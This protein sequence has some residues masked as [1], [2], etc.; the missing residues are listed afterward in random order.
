MTFVCRSYDSRSHRAQFREHAGD[1]F[2]SQYLLVSSRDLN[3]PRSSGSLTASF[4]ISQRDSTHTIMVVS[5]YS[6]GEQCPRPV[7]AWGKAN[8]SLLARPPFSF[9]GQVVMMVITWRRWGLEI[10][11][12]CHLVN[13]FPLFNTRYSRKHAF[14]KA[15]LN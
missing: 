9:F 4:C 15:S 8:C 11:R 7:R 5:G 3:L 12:R 13:L 10:E 2:A 1:V 14:L 6:T